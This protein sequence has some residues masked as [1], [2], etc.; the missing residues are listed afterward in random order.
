MT[1]QDEEEN[2]KWKDE[3]IRRAMVACFQF[4]PLG[5]KEPGKIYI[6]MIHRQDCT[7]EV[8]D[9]KIYV[10]IRTR[11]GRF[12]DK[13]HRFIMP[14]RVW[15]VFRLLLKGENTTMLKRMIRYPKEI[16]QTLEI[17]REINRPAEISLKS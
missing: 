13:N 12:D 7:L 5:G 11:I 16:D 3:I 14:A 8:Y 15:Q 10:V 2:L 1:K 9:E 17:D 4:E 6:H